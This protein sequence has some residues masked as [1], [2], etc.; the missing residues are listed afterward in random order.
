[1][2]Y[3]GA[4]VVLL[5]AFLIG[6]GTHVP[7]AAQLRFEKSASRYAA[8]QRLAKSF[9]QDANPDITAGLRGYRPGRTA[10]LLPARTFDAGYNCRG[11]VYLGK[12]DVPWEAVFDTGSTRNT[13]SW[14]FLKKSS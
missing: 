9:R 11:F 13:I 6:I 8:T 5:L 7:G 4:L 2:R 12:S 10:Q 1:M 3:L 14:E